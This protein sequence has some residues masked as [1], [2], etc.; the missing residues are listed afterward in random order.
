[1]ARRKSI[2]GRAA[3]A[4]TS[5]AGKAL[6]AAAVAATTVV[7]E[8][9]F[10]AMKDGNGRVSDRKLPPP[11]KVAAATLVRLTAPKPP[12]AKKKAAKK[13]VPK[14]VAKKAARKPIGKAARRKHR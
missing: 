1:M 12:R 8:S 14:K 3:G 11:E 6:G 7:V 4:V 2:L 13:K 9:V 10:D 5:V